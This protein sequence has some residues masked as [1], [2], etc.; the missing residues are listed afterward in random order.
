MQGWSLGEVLHLLKDAQGA[1]SLTEFADELGVSK[2]Y[3][4]NVFNGHDPPSD[5][6]L[7]NFGYVRDDIYI[8]EPRQLK[9]EKTMSTAV[10]LGCAHCAQ[11]FDTDKELLD[12]V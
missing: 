2:Q 12:H 3:L 7:K 11:E 8:R 5:R 9:R 4:S 10:K 6:L 1:K